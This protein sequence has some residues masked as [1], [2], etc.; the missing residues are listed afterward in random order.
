LFAAPDH[1]AVSANPAAPAPGERKRLRALGTIAIMDT[2]AEERF[3]RHTRLVADVMGASVCFISFVDR[4][5]EWVKSAVGTAWREVGRDVAAGEAVLATASVFEIADLAADERLAANPLVRESPGRRFY[6]GVR[7]RGPHGTPVGT[8]SILGDEPRRLTEPERE[9][10]AAFAGLVESELAVDLEFGDAAGGI[11]ATL[12]QDPLTRLPG[13]LLPE[14]YA[15]DWIA[16]L[17]PSESLVAVHVHIRNLEAINNAYGRAVGDELVRL[18]ARRAHEAAPASAIVA[19]LSG[20]RL[21]VLIRLEGGREDAECPVTDVVRAMGQPTDIAPD[22]ISPDLDV[23]VAVAPGDVTQGD[24]LIEK[25]RCA[26][27]NVDNADRDALFRF[28]TPETEAASEHLER[29]PFRLSNAVEEGAIAIRFQ[30]I[31][32][33]KRDT[34]VALE[35]LVRWDDSAL[36]ELQPGTFIPH[37]EADPRLARILTRHV[38]EAACDQIVAMGR[39]APAISVNV[40]ATDLYQPDFEAFVLGVIDDAN[41]PRDQIILE[42]TEQSLIADA[43]RAV[44]TLRGLRDAGIRC[45][46][47]DFGTGYSS[48]SYLRRLPVQLLKLDRSFVTD[49][50]AD[51]TGD[52]VT[53]GI[54]TIGRSLGLQVIAEGIE[55]NTD[56]IRAKALGCDFGQGYLLGRPAPG[57]TLLD[58]D[59][60]P[61]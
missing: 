18:V 43:D 5:R 54:V 39:N 48:L 36:G 4:Y 19:R 29:I 38:L 52:G 55:T 40:A 53:A 34:I 33:L 22:V 11:D 28:Y 42:L 3:D 61:E 23:G 26:L 1:D 9:R 41:V 27:G 2:P 32:D 45:A 35:A 13:P 8:L 51:S 44:R 58:S 30:P 56:L 16:E 20:A 57:E 15:A 46:L 24:A 7:L 6:A 31:H 21:V 50:G 37:V 47:D 59:R 12:F 60:I 10:L 14:D 49:S 17:A 25:A